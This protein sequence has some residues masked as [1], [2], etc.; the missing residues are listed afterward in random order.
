MDDYS[1]QTQRA[2]L[3]LEEQ[4]QRLIETFG[5]S[6]QKYLTQ[7]RGVSLDEYGELSG[8]ARSKFSDGKGV[9]VTVEVDHDGLVSIERLG[10]EI[11]LVP[12]IVYGTYELDMRKRFATER[13]ID[14]LDSVND[15]FGQYSL[16]F[17][18]AA[19]ICPKSNVADIAVKSVP[20]LSTGY[21]VA[22]KQEQLERESAIEAREALGMSLAGL[23]QF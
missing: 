11:L 6:I 9:S 13:V 20:D 19:S 22:R 7:S 2:N 3:K 1:R 5:G 15:Q 16:T 8:I 14:L 17:R 23:D 12:D 4:A 21:T 18:Y 10:V